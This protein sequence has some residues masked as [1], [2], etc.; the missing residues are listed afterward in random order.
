MTAYEVNRFFGR[1]VASFDVMKYCILDN[2]SRETTHRR[3]NVSMIRYDL[4][5]WRRNDLSSFFVL[6]DDFADPRQRSETNES[7]I[8]KTCLRIEYVAS[9]KSFKLGLASQSNIFWSRFEWQE[10]FSYVRISRWGEW[11]VSRLSWLQISSKSKTEDGH[12]L[13][14]TWQL[15]CVRKYS[16]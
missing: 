11:G 4:H 2:D 3:E 8:Q 13:R 10:L 16:T 9:S 14:L 15:L 5:P 1:K 7:E 6:T 12:Q